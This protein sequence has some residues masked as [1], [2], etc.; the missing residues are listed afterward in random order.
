MILVKILSIIC[1]TA[2]T[3]HESAIN[4]VNAASGEEKL[5]I[6]KKFNWYIPAAL[7][8]HSIQIIYFNNV[9]EIETIQESDN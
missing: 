5:I 6:S 9:L 8:T 4:D 2:K 1:Q 7:K 3:I